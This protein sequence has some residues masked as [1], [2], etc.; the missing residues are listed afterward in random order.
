MSVKDECLLILSSQ[1]HCSLSR[2]STSRR[3][4]VLQPL[5]NSAAFL[6]FHPIVALLLLVHPSLCSSTSN[7]LVLS[8][9][10]RRRLH[11]DTV[12]LVTRWRITPFEL[13]LTL[14]GQQRLVL[15]SV[16][17][18]ETTFIAL[19]THPLSFL[20]SRFPG[21]VGFLPPLSSLSLIIVCVFGLTSSFNTTRACTLA[22]RGL[23]LTAVPLSPAMHVVLGLGAFCHSRRTPN[24][25]LPGL[26]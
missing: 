1:M 24:S 18:R 17:P 4:I 3:F 7:P 13:R 12:V 22:T 15:P 19:P 26:S 2:V 20:F 9:L 8:E 11:R 10:S 14:R 5:R 21:V 6:S 23:G 16:L 25:R